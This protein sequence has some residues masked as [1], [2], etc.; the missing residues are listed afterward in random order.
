[1][2]KIR[3]IV[4][5]VLL[6]IGSSILLQQNPTEAS[7][8]AKAT[9][10]KARYKHT[11]KG[12]YY[13]VLTG[14]TKKNKKVWSHKSSTYIP[15]QVDSVTYKRKGKYVYLFDRRKLKVFKLSSG[16]KIR[17]TKIKIAGGHSFA[18]DS[19]YN[20]YLTGYFYDDVYKLDKKGR[21]KW[22][23]NIKYLGFGDAYGTTYKK[24]ILTIYYESSPNGGDLDLDKH[25][26]VKFDAKTGK[27][28]SYRK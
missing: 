23:T 28:L 8:K 21:T 10:V 14:Y 26:Y 24:G 20:L 2:K 27:V 18:F 17:Q 7:P 9:K 5:L 22:H 12:K 11:K 13:L 16:K 19:K 1:M 25:Y 3:I 15:A 4:T 6:G